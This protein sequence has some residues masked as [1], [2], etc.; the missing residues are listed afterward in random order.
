MRIKHNREKS[1]AAYHSKQYYW[2]GNTPKRKKEIERERE[3]AKIKEKAVYLSSLWK[4]KQ[5]R[6]ANIEKTESDR[7]EMCGQWIL[8]AYRSTKIY[9][10]LGGG[11]VNEEW[12]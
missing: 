5:C 8:T 10:L 6:E 12:K 11:E 2:H 4:K 3:G 1:T 7:N 9:C